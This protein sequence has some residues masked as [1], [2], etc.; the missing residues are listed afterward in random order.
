MAVWNRDLIVQKI[1]K[2]LGDTKQ[3]LTALSGGTGAAKSV[4]RGRCS[5]Y[6]APQNNESIYYREINISPVNIRK[7]IVLINGSIGSTNTTDV[8]LIDLTSN[9]LKLGSPT[10]WRAG[11]YKNISWQVIEF[12]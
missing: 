6:G 4:Q 12:Y 7:S 1:D 8:F 11:E 2:V 5:F 9:I 10:G 3:I